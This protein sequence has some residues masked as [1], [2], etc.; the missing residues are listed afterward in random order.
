MKMMSKRAMALAAGLAATSLAACDD[1]GVP[2]PTDVRVVFTAPEVNATLTCADDLDRSTDDLLEVHIEALIQNQ[3]APIDGL[4]VELVIDDDEA[5][6][7]SQAVPI[8]GVLVF[9]AVPLALGDRVLVMR[10]IDN[11]TVIST[12]RRVVNASI[13]PADPACDGVVPPALVFV[14]PTA[15]AVLDEAGDDDLADDLQITVELSAAG[16]APVT[17]T[18]NGEAASEASPVDGTVTFEGVTLPIGDGTNTESVLRAVQ[19]EAAAEITVSVA[20]DGCTVA[21]SPEPI[22]GCWSPDAD[23]DPGTDGVQVEFIAA[24]NCGN[25]SFEHNGIAGAPIDVVDGVATTTITLT[26]G[27]NSVRAEARTDGGLIGDAIGDYLLGDGG[28]DITLDL[29]ANDRRVRA[30]LDDGGVRQWTISGTATDAA[31]GDDVVINGLAADVNATV[32]ADG[33]FSFPVT[34]DYACPVTLQVTGAD[35][36]GA[37]GTSPEYTVCF[38]AISPLLE[39]IDPP[40][41]GVLVDGNANTPGIQT[42][43]SVRVNDA[44]PA[45]VDYDI[46]IECGTDG[47]FNEYSIARRA[48]SD[49]EDG[50]VI[51]PVDIRLEDGVYTCRATAEAVNNAATTPGINVSID[52]TVLGFTI[53][54]PDPDAAPT[55]SDA[56]TVAGAGA[57]LS[58]ANA[59]LVAVVDGDE[60]FEVA[61]DPTAADAF[62]V[63]LATGEGNFTVTVRGMSDRGPVAI[64]PAAPIPFI[65]DRTAPTLGLVSPAAGAE[66]GLADDA[67]DD[68]SDCVQTQVTVSL[69]DANTDEICW[70]LNGGVESCGVVNANGQ[71]VSDQVSLRDGENTIAVR[72]VDC[73]GNESNE[74]FMVSTAGCGEDPRSLAITTPNDGGTVR[75]IEDVDPALDSCQI[76]VIA[77]GV[78]FANGTEFIVCSNLGPAD[79]R[80]PGGGAAVSVDDCESVGDPAQNLTCRVTLPDGEHQLTAV[81]L[82]ANAFSSEA[83]ALTVDCTPPSVQRLVLV[84]DDGDGC[85]NGGE[86]GEVDANGAYAMTLRATVEGM[87]EGQPV[88]AW[89]LPEN[90][91]IN[92]GVVNA[93]VATID[94]VLP[95]GEHSVYVTGSDAAGNDSP[96]PDDAL[97]LAVRVDVRAPEPQLLGLV[98]DSCLNATA[99]ANADLADMQYGFSA[100]AGGDPSEV[101]SARLTIDGDDAAILEGVDALVDFMPVDLG[102]GDHAVAITV[103]DACGNVGSVAGFDGDAP[104]TFAV[105]VD[106]I[107]PA[108]TLGGL[109]DGQMLNSDDD[110]ADLATD[111]LQVQVAVNFDG[112]TGP[113]AGQDINIRAGA[114]LLA[115]L[116]GDGGDGPFER[117]VTLPGGDSAVTASATDACGNVG[118]SAPINISVTID[119]CASMITG[120]A[121]NPAPIGPANGAVV[122]DALQTTVTG[123]VAIGCG[124]GT[125]DLLVDGESVAST[126]VGNGDISFPDVVLAEGARAL[127]L[128]VRVGPDSA[129]SPVQTVVVDLTAPSVVIDTPAG[130][131]PVVIFD[132]ADPATDGQQVVVGATVTEA[133]DGTA[134]TA[135]LTLNG[136]VLAGPIPVAPGSPVALDFGAVTVPAGDG[137]LEVCVLDM[138]ANQ[139]CAALQVSIDA[140]APGVVEPTAVITDPRTTRV[141]IDFVAPADDGE[142]GGRVVRYR[143]RRSDQPIVTEEDWRAAEFI[144]ATGTTVDPGELERIVLIRLLALN[145]VHY[146]AVRGVDENDREGAFISVPVDLRLSTRS[147]DIDAPFAGDDFFN[148]GS[149]VVGA[150][151]LD[152]DGLGDFLMYG[153]QLTGEAAAAVV[154]GGDGADAAQ[155]NLTLDPDSTF[156]ATDAGALGDVNGDGVDDIALLGYSAAFDASRVVLYFGGARADMAAPDAVITLPGRLTNFVTGVGNFTGG[157]G[158][159]FND[160]FIGGSPGGGGTTAFV[161]HGRAN[162]PAE[163]DAVN[164][165]DGVTQLTIPEENAG[166]FAAGIGDIDGDG[167]ADLALGGGGNFNVTYVFYGAR[168]L[169]ILPIDNIRRVALVNPCIAPST[170]FGSWFAGGRDLTGDGTPD[171]LV[172]ARGHKRVVVFDQ[173]LASVDC[174]GR[175]EVQFG[176]NFDIAG[177]LNADGNLDL[178]VTHRDNQGRPSDAMAFYNDGT[179][180][181]GGPTLPRVPDVRFTEAQRPRLGAAGIGDFNGD[182]RDDVVTIYKVQGGPLR[183]IVH[184]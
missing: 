157:L 6:K 102:E 53:T 16:D 22:D 50:V 128:R 132:D 176:V 151:D 141:R 51:I 41:D 21:L 123:A 178:I 45:E 49:A 133:L 11:G 56:A 97:Q 107:A 159:G 20:I 39:I 170:S 94:L 52:S 65:V 163:L 154:F 19:G 44:R 26:P 70:S 91:I 38:D 78:G 162:W 8:E 134:R 28:P 29:E 164:A 124:G 86:A 96:G 2:T 156:A 112:G 58:A 14:T 168:E 85:I 119:A 139:G 72:A 117:M 62:G 92:A 152:N 5:G 121:S 17:L 93:G 64:A 113:E 149:L 68:L 143:V 114:G 1:G 71:F 89:R 32:G 99:D 79:P 81:S 138:A 155:V 37:E 105:R 95:E 166:V 115:T 184:F 165:V 181:F 69:A 55:C 13:D 36:C 54:T 118:E 63:A 146:I 136:L 73:A 144:L 172:G 30:D 15:D 76:D 34:V 109:V 150:G 88:T 120:F 147:F 82:E 169:P 40:A 12:A 43:F 137:L 31:E 106:T 130:V 74:M 66:L 171:F 182:G 67:N 100:N 4:R 60:S 103:T 57:G 108:P 59:M 9:N 174:V 98:P 160:I 177:D 180:H 153:N 18:V 135:T 47:A 10:L 42:A 175:N 77:G 101:L 48:R 84:E 167:N 145:K 158:D 183:A 75:L 104:D 80:C 129:D 87:P 148:G 23:I 35:A 83:I 142:E 131:E 179:G 127:S 25:V 27:S 126:N 116:P 90:E 24:T 3:G 161:V 173:D 122:G 140:G 111:G 61:L 33:R 110:D 125:V 46:G 7:L